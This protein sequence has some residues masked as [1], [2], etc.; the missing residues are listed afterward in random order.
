MPGYGTSDQIQRLTHVM[1]VLY[2][3]AISLGS[4]HGL[5]TIL[6]LG[7]IKVKIRM[8]QN[9][10][11]PIQ[12]LNPVEIRQHLSNIVF[13]MPKLEGKHKQNGFLVPA[14]LQGSG[15]PPLRDPGLLWGP[16]ICDLIPSWEQINTE[17]LAWTQCFSFPVATQQYILFGKWHQWGWVEPVG[18]Q[19][20]RYNNLPLKAR[21]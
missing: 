11:G 8:P 2:H 16:Q 12:S 19:A 7:I 13:Q 21:F 3:W 6:S 5:P 18:A 15:M 17:A 14:V 9:L 20:L 1:S 10:L 4:Y